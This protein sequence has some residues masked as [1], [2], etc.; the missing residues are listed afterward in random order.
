MKTRHCTEDVKHE[1]LGSYFFCYCYSSFFLPL[2]SIKVYCCLSSFLFLCILRPLPFSSLFF[3]LF[4]TLTPSPPLT[5]ELK[6]PLSVQCFDFWSSM[7]Q[8]ANDFIQTS[9][10]SQVWS[11]CATK[12][13]YYL[14]RVLKYSYAAPNLLSRG[15]DD[16]V[17]IV[18]VSFLRV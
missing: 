13:M 15:L 3:P 9:L 10:G 4:L 1:L 6:F 18:Q 17:I 14:V 2:L 7:T 16:F 12:S 8:A 5:V 11:I